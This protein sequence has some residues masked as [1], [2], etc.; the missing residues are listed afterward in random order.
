MDSINLFTGWF[1]LWN[2][3][4]INLQAH[5]VC[6]HIFIQVNGPNS[7]KTDKHLWLKI[8]YTTL[9]IWL[10]CIDPVPTIPLTPSCLN[11]DLSPDFR[12]FEWHNSVPQC[13]HSVKPLLTHFSICATLHSRITWLTRSSDTCREQNSTP[14]NPLRL[15]T[16]HQYVIWYRK[17][18]KIVPQTRYLPQLMTQRSIISSLCWDKSQQFGMARQ[19]PEPDVL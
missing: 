8:C 16:W 5:C 18:T 15:C 3:H 1:V 19:S 11:L 10:F 2:H 12:I 7:W 9:N 13:I 14:E 4:H 17:S 6:F